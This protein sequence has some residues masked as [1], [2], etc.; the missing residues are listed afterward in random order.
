MFTF[1]LLFSSLAAVPDIQLLR[2]TCQLSL[3]LFSPMAVCALHPPPPSF[4]SSCL[5]ATGCGPSVTGGAVWTGQSGHLASVSA[6]NAPWPRPRLGTPLWG[7]EGGGCGWAGAQLGSRGEITLMSRP[8]HPLWRWGGGVA[9]T[10]RD[11]ESLWV[12]FSR[13]HHARSQSLWAFTY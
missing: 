2:W 1:P 5:R 8:R 9:W 6:W 11:T 10:P 12:C 13:G 7:L 3:H 4:S